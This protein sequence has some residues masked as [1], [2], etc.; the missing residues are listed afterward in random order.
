MS[1]YSDVHTAIADQDS[2]WEAGTPLEEADRADI[3]TAVETALGAGFTVSVRLEQG[4]L[5]VQATLVPEE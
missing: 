1:K 3:Q 2:A 4:V 5:R